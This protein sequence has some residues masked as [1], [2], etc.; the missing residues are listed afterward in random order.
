M[1]FFDIDETLLCQRRAEAVAAVALLRTFAH[2]LPEHSTAETLS[3][4]WRELREAH[5]P[6]FLCGRI[7]HRE[8]HRR[9]IR[10]LFCDGAQLTDRECDQ[11]YDVYLES[12]RNAWSLFDDV[13]PTLDRLHDRPLGIVSNGGTAQQ[14]HKLTWTGIRERFSVVLISEEVR[15]GKPSPQIFHAACRR[16]GRRPHEC[17]YIG[18]RLAAD[19]QASR[20]AGLRGIWLDRERSGANGDVEVIHSLAELPERLDLPAQGHRRWSEPEW[21]GDPRDESPAGVQAVT[22]P[23]QRG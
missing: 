9:R 11:R 2:V 17:V 18:D 10:A 8:H 21:N 1:I 15:A 13:L 5:L 3:R 16:A 14:N 4:R 6:A 20:F 22:S 19:A 7:S 12:Y 23:F